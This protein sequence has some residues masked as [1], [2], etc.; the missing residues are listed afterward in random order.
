MFGITGS[1]LLHS[2]RFLTYSDVRIKKNIQ[3]INGDAAL[4]QILAI[5]PKTCN[6]KL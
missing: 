1:K 3:D 4:Q 2:Q 5:Q 6:I